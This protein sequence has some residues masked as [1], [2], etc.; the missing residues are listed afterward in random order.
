MRFEAAS[1]MYMQY[2]NAID[3]KDIT[4]SAVFSGILKGFVHDRT[5]WT[6]Y[7]LGDCLA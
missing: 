7:V 5:N 6:D 2:D 1:V 4:G 3:H